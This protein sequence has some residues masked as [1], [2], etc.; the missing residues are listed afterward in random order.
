MSD[1]IGIDLAP[2]ASQGENGE[3]QIELIVPSVHCAG[4]IGRIERKLQAEPDIVRARLN[5]GSK[6]L[7]LAWKGDR[8]RAS[9]LAQQVVAL[10]YDIHPVNDLTAE[11][12]DATGKTLLRAIAVAGFAAGNIML[13]SVSIW[14]GADETTRILFHWISALIALPAV[15][16]AGRPFFRSAFRALLAKSLNMDVPISLAVL[17]ATGMSLYETLQGGTHTYFDAAVTLL[18]FLLVGRYLDF[19]MRARA[20]AVAGNLLNIDIKSVTILVDGKE[21]VVGVADV[22]PGMEIRLVAGDQVPFDGKIT[23]GSSEFDRALLTGESMPELLAPGA[24]IHAGTI[25][26]SGPVTMLVKAVGKDTVLAEIVRLMEDAEQGRAKYVRIA[27]RAAQIY[28]PLV[29]LVAVLTFAGWMWVTGGDW[30]TALLAATAVLIITCPCALGLAVP[31]VHVAACGRM[32]NKGVLVREGAGLEKLSEI[33]TVIFDK[34]G[35]LTLGTP[36]LVSSHSPDEV[37]NVAGLARNSRHP[38]SRAICAALADG[39]SI[40]EYDSIVDAPGQGLEGRLEGIVARLGNAE[41][42]GVPVEIDESETRTGLWFRRGDDAPVHFAFEDSLRVGA[43]EAIVEFQSAGIDCILLSG[44]RDNVVESIAQA[45]GISKW[46]ARC[47]PADKVA[48]VKSLQDAGHKVFMVGDGINDAPALAAAHTSISPGKAADISRAT[49]GFIFLGARLDPVFDAFETAT[50]AASL[51][52][53]NFALAIAYN[54]I[55]IPV[56][57]AG[58]ATP[59]VAAIAMS[60]SSILVTLNALRIGVGRRQTLKSDASRSAPSVLNRSSTM[61]EPG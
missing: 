55:A 9:E 15:L 30:H 37:A 58:L 3:M 56:A 52:R 44:D 17:L 5:L 47:L 53:Q 61:V 6:R 39:A 60:S 13:L 28:A 35:T 41:W 26:L 20:R 4:C 34:T 50:R 16:Y 49:A 29:H 1:A 48:R 14:S 10:G 11:D 40:P 57:I 45:V 22:V 24:T 25:N 18:L 46:Q 8:T 31:A 51:V 32:L 12:K 23:A 43:K 21:S 2:Y 33:D 54:L 19:R 38:L 36:N 27:D 42:C 7:V 59:L